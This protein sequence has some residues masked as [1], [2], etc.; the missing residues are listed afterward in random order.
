[1]KIAISGKGGVG[2]TTVAALLARA[3]SRHG[4]RVIAIDADPD[5]NLAA[6]LGHP[7]PDSIVPLSKHKD[8]I[9][10]RVGTGGVIRLNPRVDD[11]VDTIAAD[12]DGIKLMVLGNIPRGGSGC[13]CSPSALLKA[14]MLHLLAQPD[15]WVILDMEAGLEHLGR[16]SSGGVDGLLIIVEPGQRSIETA[17][18][19]SALASDLGIRQTWCVANKVRGDDDVRYLRDALAPLP[20]IGSIPISDSLSGFTARIDGQSSP[21]DIND[22]IEG[23]LE[24]IQSSRSL[25]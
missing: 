11:L 22:R 16:G 23:I 25:R 15:E 10:E 6:S 7:D 12:V 17:R 4:R 13:F 18:R 8:L 9:N 21:P 1:M 2:K 5:S 3:V 24:S 19:I 20:L 14:L